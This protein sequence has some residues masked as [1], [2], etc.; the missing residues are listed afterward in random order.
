AP[1]THRWVGLVGY[2]PDALPVVSEVRPDVWAIG[3]YSGTGNVLGALCGRGV[4]QCAV[5]G[6]SPLVAPL[7]GAA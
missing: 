4:A 5:R 6:E 1:I 3:G 2:T 7:I